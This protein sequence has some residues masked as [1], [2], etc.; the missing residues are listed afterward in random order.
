MAGTGDQVQERECGCPGTRGPSLVAQ[1]PRCSRHRRVPAPLSAREGGAGTVTSR[2]A[3]PFHEAD[4]DGGRDVASPSQA[5]DFHPQV[6]LAQVYAALFQQ[7]APSPCG[8]GSR[9]RPG[10]PT[11]SAPPPAAVWGTEEPR[12][13]LPGPSGAQ[14]LSVPA[15]EGNPAGAHNRVVYPGAPPPSGLASE[16]QKAPLTRRLLVA[17]LAEGSV[18]G[19]GLG[20]LCL[21][22]SGCCANTPGWRLTRQKLTFSQ[23][24][25]LDVCGQASRAALA[26]APP[27]RVVGRLLLQVL[28]VPASVWASGR[29]NPACSTF[30]EILSLNMASGR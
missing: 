30:S 10:T 4:T 8:Y 20:A 6:I 22:S 21:F 13:N 7:V 26:K 3:R 12:E 2:H 9:V 24:W 16:A 14:S 11:T 27:G 18:A 1:R 19:G 29:Q 5:P 15:S 17:V 25:G 28:R 23:S